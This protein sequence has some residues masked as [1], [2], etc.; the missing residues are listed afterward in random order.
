MPLNRFLGHYYAYL[1][2]FDFVLCYA[3]YTALFELAG[4]SF[5]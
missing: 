3:I 1:F 5:T 2:L 4:L